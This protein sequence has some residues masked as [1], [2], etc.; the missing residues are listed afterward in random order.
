MGHAAPSAVTAPGGT[1]EGTDSAHRSQ[2]ERGDTHLQ[3]PRT[4][5]H[6]VEVVRESLHAALYACGSLMHH[7]RGD[8][9]GAVVQLVVCMGL[10]VGVY[11]SVRK[12]C[13]CVCDK[14]THAA[15]ARTPPLAT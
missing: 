13:V 3:V 5:L 8:A 4:G 14:H 1:G 6:A 2:G 10:G 7:P 15:A 11:G 9:K 12:V